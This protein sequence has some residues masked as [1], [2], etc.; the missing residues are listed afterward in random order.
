LRHSAINTPWL[1][2]YNQKCYIKLTLTR[3]II[4]I[5]LFFFAFQ[6]YRSTFRKYWTNGH[7]LTTKSGLKWLFLSAIVEWQRHT[8]EFQYWQSMAPM[9]DSMAWGESI[10]IILNPVNCQMH[11]LPCCSCR[12]MQP[13]TIRHLMQLLIV[14]FRDQSIYKDTETEIQVR[15]RKCIFC[16][17]LKCASCIININSI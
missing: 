7:K 17:L 8:H 10:D 5:S 6:F 13:N 11:L 14:I 1:F 12:S 15:Q 9:T 3:Y 2:L 16:I 4:F